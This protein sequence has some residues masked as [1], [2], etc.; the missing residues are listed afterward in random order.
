MLVYHP[1]DS[2]RTRAFPSESQCTQH[3]RRA[4]YACVRGSHRMIRVA[5]EMIALLLLSYQHRHWTN[6]TVDENTDLATSYHF[7]DSQF[8]CYLVINIRTHSLSMKDAVFICSELLKVKTY[9]KLNNFTVFSVHNYFDHCAVEP[10]S[11]V[12]SALL[13]PGGPIGK[14]SQV[15]PREGN[16]VCPT[17]LVCSRCSS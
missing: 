8:M 3:T 16:N 7:W 13:S 4:L 9:L 2:F 15:C 10:S 5:V 6:G 11:G 12:F 1:K 14:H 17:G